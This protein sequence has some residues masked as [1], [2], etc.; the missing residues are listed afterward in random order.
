MCHILLPSEG[1]M[2]FKR[3]ETKHNEIKEI[4]TT[5][6]ELSVRIQAGEEIEKSLIINSKQKHKIFYGQKRN[7]A[8]T[9]KMRCYG[10]SCEF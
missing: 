2:S 1:I 6:R 3:C 4:S 10:G 5:S 8:E 7:V 9:L